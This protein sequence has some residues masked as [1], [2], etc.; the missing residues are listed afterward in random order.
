MPLIF[1]L[2]CPLCRFRTELTTGYAVVD[3][4]DGCEAICPHPVEVLRAHELTG[5]GWEDLVEDDRIGYRHSLTCRSCGRSDYYR[6]GRSFS[7]AGAVRH[8]GLPTGLVDGITY[9]PNWREAAEHRCGRCHGTSLVPSIEVGRAPGEFEVRCPR[10][11]LR[12][13]ERVT[14][15]IS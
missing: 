4:D 11:R 9:V 3:L 10:C 13:L 15:A 2:R 1:E 14:T 7:D 8:S 5:L 6:S 12:K